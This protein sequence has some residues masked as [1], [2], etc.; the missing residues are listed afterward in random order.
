[1][2]LWLVSGLV[3]LLVLG[4]LFWRGPF[5]RPRPES[6]RPAEPPQAQPALS[7]AKPGDVVFVAGGRDH[8]VE[9]V[10][11][12]QEEV[13]GRLT[14]WQ[15]LVLSEGWLIELLPYH[16]YLG[17]QWQVV[18]QGTP[19]FDALVGPGGALRRFEAHVREGIAA[20]EPVTLTIE[21]TSWRVSSTGSFQASA[22]GEVWPQGPVWAALSPDPADNVYFT[23]SRTEGAEERVLGLWTDHI[24]LYRERPLAEGD[25]TLYPR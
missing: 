20:Q 1:V 25:A 5:R 7:E 10:L 13:G 12:C 16:R 9:A 15:W 23:L 18:Y 8:L 17:Q 3:V 24:L 6:E 19:L 22:R 11:D 21:G 14:R 2:E 4:L